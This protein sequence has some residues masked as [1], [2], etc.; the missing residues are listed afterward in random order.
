MGRGSD[1]QSYRFDASCEWFFFSALPLSRCAQASGNRCRNTSPSS[2]PTAKLSIRLRN[3]PDSETY[4][5]HMLWTFSYHVYMQLLSTDHLSNLHTNHNVK[6]LSLQFRIYTVYSNNLFYQTT[7]RDLFNDHVNQRSYKF[8][9]SLSKCTV[10]IYLQLEQDQIKKSYDQKCCGRIIH[11]IVNRWVLWTLGVLTV[12]YRDNLK[13]TKMEQRV[14]K[15]CSKNVFRFIEIR[16]DMTWGY[17]L[18]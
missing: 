14:C 3:A 7:F 4:N 12:E 17:L 9:R 5:K 18:S 13:L 16:Q 11:R 15:T 8:I 1:T 6:F 2:A 10:V